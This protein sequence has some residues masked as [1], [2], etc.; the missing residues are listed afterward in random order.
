MT[1]LT[2]ACVFVQGNYP[3]TLDYVVR[4]ERMVR[5]HLDRPF[6]FVCFTDQPDAVRKA[7]LQAIPIPNMHLRQAFWHK[8]HLFDPANGL[9][10]RVLY[11]DLDVLVVADLDPLVDTGAPFTCAADLF[12]HGDGPPV[13]GAKDGRVVCQKHQGSVIVFDVGAV[14][15]LFTDW[16]PALA[17]HYY[18]C[19]DWMSERYPEAPVLSLAWFPR[20]SQVQPPWPEDAKVVFVK[21]PK[22]HLA[23]QQWPW[24]EPLWGA[25]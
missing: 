6:R 12:G 9:T 21:K 17:D 3:Y 5:R 23:C 15:D 14:S 1:P 24:F 2:V 16:T 11:L 8:V 20:I 10:G 25:A 13:R 22:N 4:L 7:G 18:G 19:D